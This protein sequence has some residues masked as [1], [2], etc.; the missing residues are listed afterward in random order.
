[1]V[2]RICIPILLSVLSFSAVAADALDVN[3]ELQSVEAWRTKRVAN[4]TREDG[5]LTLVGL[6]WLKEGENGLGRDPKNRVT[7]DH[8]ALPPHA[9]AFIVQ[10]NEVRFEAAAGS[11]V[12]HDGKA[13]TSLGLASDL[14][15]DPTLLTSGSLQFYLIDRTGKLGIRMRDTEHPA[16]TSFEGID[17]YSVTRDW[18][19]EARFEP[20]P[21][22]KT[23][24]IP[25]ILG[26]MDQMLNPGAL[27][28][29]KDGK[30][31]RLDALL[32]A[33]DDDEFFIIFADATSGR[34]TYGA[35][36]YMY[37]PR[38][39][40]DRLLLNFNKAYNP[41]CAFNDFATCPLPPRQNRLP[42]KVE[43]G[44]KTY[45]HH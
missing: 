9:G 37:V 25:N 39:K 10:G 29:N 31:H 2:H 6:F 16:R 35:G 15:G 11:T 19:V 30:E 3:A 36:R 13:V 33:A 44:E 4:L 14:K 26:M 27:V 34:E 17:H 23:I 40:G 32:N 18:I 1:M 21:A 38:P 7:L 28:F 24:P 41:P 43:A 20:Y 22:G 45:G 8:P 42:I 5:W 12:R